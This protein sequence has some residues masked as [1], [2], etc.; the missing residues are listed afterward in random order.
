MTSTN[1]RHRESSTA[2]SEE[3]EA[4]VLGC[5]ISS[6]ERGTGEDRKSSEEDE[7]EA[8]KSHNTGLGIGRLFGFGKKKKEEGKGNDIVQE[9]GKDMEAEAGRNHPSNLKLSRSTHPYL[10]QSPGLLRHD[11]ASP[12]VV[13]PAGS[14]IFERDVQETVSTVLPA[15]PAI[16]SHIQTENHIPAVLDASSEAITDK[17]LNPDTVEIVMHSFHQPAVMTVAGVGS[18]DATGTNW[19]EELATHPDKEDST[20]NYG[21]LDNTDVRRLSFISFADV[22]Q[23]EQAEHFNNSREPAQ[24][25]SLTGHSSGHRSSSPIRSIG[26]AEVGGASSPASKSASVKGVEVSSG[27][28]G[29][30]VASP[31]LSAQTPPPQASPS[32]L[33]IETMSQALRKTRSGDLTGAKSHTMSPTSPVDE[34]GKFS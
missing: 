4:S 28:A 17:D 11:S 1:P 6:G 15:S 10:P 23:S 26:S 29:R 14:Q 34:G 3:Q 8:R 18:S 22:V 27:R 9:N 20:S 13:S 16:P 7:E 5:K 12:R 21:A 24:A 19:S 32:E 33:T 2:R 31:S 30:L 25:A